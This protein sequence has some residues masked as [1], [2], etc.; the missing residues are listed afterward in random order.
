MLREK[1]RAYFLKKENKT[2]LQNRRF[3]YSAHNNT[4]EALEKNGWMIPLH[5]PVGVTEGL[6][7]HEK[8]E[9]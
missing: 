1:Q 6:Q 2:L 9:A 7:T 3:Q 4:V 8:K 5:Q